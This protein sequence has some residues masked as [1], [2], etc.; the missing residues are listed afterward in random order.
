VRDTTPSQLARRSCGRFRLE[1][2]GEEGAVLGRG[3]SRGGVLDRLQVDPDG[4]SAALEA[5][6]PDEVPGHR[7]VEAPAEKREQLPW[8]RDGD[9][10]VIDAP[11][12][13]LLHWSPPV[14]S[15][16][17]Q[18]TEQLRIQ[19]PWERGEVLRDFHLRLPAG[20]RLRR[21]FL[22][23]RVF[24]DIKKLEKTRDPKSCRRS[25]VGTGRVL[26]D[27]RPFITE[28]IPADLWLFL[29]KGT[30][31]RAVASL[32]ILGKQD[33]SAPV[34]R[35]IPV[36]RDFR[37][38]IVFMNILDEPTRDGKYG[39]RLVFGN[40]PTGGGGASFSIA[41]TRVV[42][43]GFSLIRRRT[44]CLERRGPRCLRKKV[45]KKQLFWFRPPRCPASGSVSF[46][47]FFG[48]ESLPDI[49]RTT[50]LS[51]PRFRP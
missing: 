28:Q 25:Q 46:E 21:E 32:A 31:R 4:D 8:G 47:A 24:C 20:V 49:V 2:D 30:T 29:A 33:Q 7:Q 12:Y 16:G 3:P 13:R 10:H 14:L 44:T 48:Y 37:A 26:V 19:S 35:D 1:G 50:V 40:S 34:V 23:K 27:A 41:E 43:K 42:N 15:R 11:D 45:G 51:C 38:P 36:V 5:R 22:N 18:A 39:Y 6:H 17:R 9:V